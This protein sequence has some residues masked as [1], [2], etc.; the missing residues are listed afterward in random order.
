MSLVPVC[1]WCGKIRLPD[2]T[3][4]HNPIATVPPEI[5]THGICPTCEREW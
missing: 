3:W 5:A 4:E 1:A 2:G